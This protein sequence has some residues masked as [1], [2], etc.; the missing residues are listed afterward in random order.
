MSAPAATPSPGL[1]RT[2]RNGAVLL[3]VI[4]AV[5]A[6]VGFLVLP[7][8]LR[9]KVE[10]HATQ[11]LD[12]RTT[13]GRLEFNP[14]TLRARLADF[15]IADRDP[16]RPFLRFDSLDVDVSAASLWKFAPILD[17]VH[18]VR[19]KIDLTRNSDGS[20]SIDDVIARLAA[21]PAGPAP[22]FSVSNIE[23]DD[24]S[25]SFDDRPHARTIVVSN[26]VIGIP[27]LSSIPHEARIRVTPRFDGLLDGARFSLVGNSNSP[28]ADTREATL[29]WNLDALPLAR[30][31]EYVT[32]P[33]G[34]KLAKGALTTRLR[35]AFVTDKSAPR[36]IALSGS[37]RI[38]ALQLARKDGSPLAS[39]KSIEAGLARLDW[40]ARSIVL[41]RIVVATPTLA[42]RRDADGALELTKT[43]AGPEGDTATKHAS[44]TTAHPW[45]VRIAETRISEGGVRFA[46]AST[47]P[48]FAAALSNI[49]FEGKEI[50]STGAPGTVELSFDAD[51]GAHLALSGRLDVANT[52]ASGHVALTKL[53][54]ARLRPYYAS[55]VSADIA[56]GKADV[57]ADFDVSMPKDALRFTLAGGAAA[58]TDLD[59]AL[60]GERH[61]FLRVGRLEVTGLSADSAKR[62]MTIDAVQ[63][64]SGSLHLLRRADGAFAVE[65]V[66]RAPPAQD[67]APRNRRSDD[68]ASTHGA[69]NDAW[70]VGVRTLTASAI[71]A[72]FDDRSQRPAVR[73]RA[74]DANITIT[75]LTNAAQGKSALDAA[76]R[77]GARG[78][79]RIRGSF[80][81]DPLAAD[82]HVD[83][84]AIDL[85]P[86]RP[87]IEAPTNVEVTSGSFG[88]SGRV[89]YAASRTGGPAVS[90]KGDLTLSDF[91]SLD[92]PTSQE[93]VRWKTLALAGVDAT[94]EPFNVAIGAIA[95]DDFYARVILNDDATL[96]LTRL[97]APKTA[98]QPATAASTMAGGV[99]TKA[100]PPPEQGRE[101]PVS[102]GHIGFSRGEVQYSD[103]FVKPNY[104][105]HLTDVSGSVSALSPA[106]AGVVEL[107][108][109]VEGSA[110]V[111][112]RGKVNPFARELAL[113]LT[114]KA[115]DVDLPPLTPYSVKYAG[116]GIQKGKL[117]LEVHY[118]ID[119]RKL[120]ATNKLRLDQL[121]FGERVDS[122]TATK[123][124]VLLAVS[125]LK[126]RN[127]VINLDLPIEGTLDDPQF[128][129]WR[130]VAQIFV[131]L[132][133][134][135]VTAPFALL[136]SIA[137]GGGEQ[138]AYVEFAPGHADV[139]DASRTKLA[140]LAKALTDRPGLRIDAAGRAIADADRDGLK[141][142]MLDHALRARKAKALAEGGES[143]PPLE[144]L[145]ID[146]AEYPKLLSAVYRDT[147]L[148][149]KPRNFLGIAKT[150]PPAEMEALLLASYGVDDAALTALANR[151]AEAVKQWFTH[152]G[153]IAAERVFVVAPKMGKEGIKDAGSPTRV[154]FA[155]R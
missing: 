51:D 108:G 129:V 126:D 77:I 65:R 106:L 103:Y 130:V 5:Y 121:T 119:N 109:R 78:R 74:A 82:V 8:L 100:L 49:T 140:T 10:T 47:A 112:L 39:A 32:L 24:G 94:R 3:A 152:D 149:N 2:L 75:N 132:V 105:A 63:W 23:V 136:G 37:A 76:L 86:L 44:A 13:L 144:S 14:F 153:A 11:L 134:K 151:R 128:S 115:S 30:Y 40:L 142:A 88:A 92:R 25:V 20:Y 22:Q 9:P 98:A 64:R 155:I 59:A 120:A 107:A 73:L 58:I 57:A 85:V 60:R 93:L 62:N 56:R 97:L 81:T 43:M 96:N 147:D 19:P 1:A 135:A 17:E 145:T 42:L 104:T 138:L 34:L 146:A 27:F 125:L 89:V 111:E 69:A 29:E 31:G 137:G 141:H 33:G 131:N 95:M 133:T 91:G 48:G 41:D 36:T 6:L 154:D 139:T 148:P 87:Y 21:R 113:D 123:L 116:Y 110:P 18:V 68:S 79:L 15:A 46:D 7:S 12:R 53:D 72:D 71:A 124:P 26:V 50:A 118:A 55:A 70:S 80:A 150:I 67:R 117:A 16:Q 84:N 99:T 38:D 35:L 52:A 61:P 45:K 143:S 122:P 90:Y 4:A 28:F 114:G 127:G 102:I 54:L 101:V 66:I 83:A